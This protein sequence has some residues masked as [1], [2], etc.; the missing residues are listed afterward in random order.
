MFAIPFS[1]IKCKLTIKNSQ[2]QASNSHLRLRG[3]IRVGNS[4][5]KPTKH[6]DNDVS[7]TVTLTSKKSFSFRDAKGVHHSGK[8]CTIV[9]K[10]Y[11]RP[12]SY[13]HSG[14]KK[15]VY[16]PFRLAKDI[17]CDK[18]KKSHSKK[19][20]SKHSKKKTS[21]KTTKTT[22]KKSSSKFNGV[23]T[24]FTP[25]QGACGEWNDNYDMIAAV[26]GD[27][28]GSYS[29][30]S[31]VCGKKVLV[32]NKANG[33]SVKVTITDACES[34]DKTHIDLSPGAFAKIG[35]FDTGVLNVEWH[36][37]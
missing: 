30:K 34:C 16:L 4:H 32:T 13:H 1:S 19:T 12:A 27:L 7:T 18:D 5:C 3:N 36:Y 9:A 8:K 2:L 20:K 10:W 35:K 11:N 33:K 37:I 26:G 28:Y 17:R 31:K 29:K 6:D 14:S 23:A 25:N 15:Q 22:K 24:F 21:K